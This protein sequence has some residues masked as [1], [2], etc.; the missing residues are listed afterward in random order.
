MS[1]FKIGDIIILKNR[2]NNPVPR[3]IVAINPNDYAVKVLNNTGYVYHLDFD[4]V[5]ERYEEFPIYF[6]PLYQALRE[7]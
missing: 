7:I 6:S 5:N 4:I 3:E 2:E 1:K